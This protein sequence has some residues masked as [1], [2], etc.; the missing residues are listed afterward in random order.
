MLSSSKLV[1]QA[2]RRSSSAGMISDSEESRGYLSE[3]EQYRRS[4]FPRPSESAN[5]INV[6]K[7]K[8]MPVSKR[9]STTQ[10]DV[11]ITQNSPQLIYEDVFL[12]KRSG[13][14]N[15][16]ITKK[17]SWNDTTSDS[18]ISEIENSCPFYFSTLHHNNKR[19]NILRQKNERHPY[20]SGNVQLENI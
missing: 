9:F 10:T 3:G 5:D 8:K 19:R 20:K 12:K 6:E 14:L 15:H 18:E 2:Q 11:D 7:V 13:R 16:K 17:D 1:L 4:R